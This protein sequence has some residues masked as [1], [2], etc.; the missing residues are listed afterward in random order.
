MSAPA[1][2]VPSGLELHH[3]G[4]VVDDLESAAERYALLGFGS[5]ER[6]EMPQQ[7]VVALTYHAGPGYVELITPTDP[8]GPIARFLGKRGNSLHHVAYR[9]DDLVSTLAE[10]SASGVRLIDEVPRTG[11]HGWQI[12]FVHPESCAG[13]LTELVQVGPIPDHG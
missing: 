12:A 4:V 1:A 6:F 7:G 5:G 10:L 3:V 11:T 9:T 8:E 13:V 2:F